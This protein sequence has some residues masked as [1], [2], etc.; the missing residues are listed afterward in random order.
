MSE[1]C[2]NCYRPKQCC[3]CSNIKPFDTNSKFVILMHPKEAKKE[4]LGT[5]RITHC[6]LKNSEII[7]D[8]DFTDNNQLN[9]LINSKN[10]QTLLLYPGS[11]SINISSEFEK[12]KKVSTIPF[13]VIVIDGTWPLAKKIMKLS[14]NLH[15]LDRISFSPTTI[16][17]F[18]IKQQPNDLCLSTIESVHRVL[19]LFDNYKVESLKGSHQ[20]LLDVFK[21]LIDFQISCANDKTI[22]SYRKGSYKKQDDRKKSKKWIKRNVFY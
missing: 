7:V 15:N 17:Q 20:N 6:C 11:Q 12:I 14:S 5:G 18:I 2:Y 3:L 16:S 19:D 8:I 9:N 1:R 10:Y 4:R 13:L 21:D 22:K